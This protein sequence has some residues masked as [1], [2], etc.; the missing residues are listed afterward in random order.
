MPR[1]HGIDVN[2]FHPVYDWDRLAEQRFEIFGAKATNGLGIDLAFDGHRGG[3]REH[4]F[5]LVV[6]YHFPTPK[7]S[8]V[9]QADHFV[10]QVTIGGLGRNERLALD[11][12]YDEHNEW[13]PDIRFV[14]EFTQEVIRLIS[15]RRMFTYTSKRVWGDYMGGA[16]WPAAIATDA[17]L[18]HYGTDEPELPLDRQGFPLWPR[19]TMWQDSEEFRCPGVGLCDHNFFAGDRDQLL[20][21]MGSVTAD[22]AP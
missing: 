2:H 8:A 17:W 1:A 3:A 20:A 19:W 11:V 7:S 18:A 10:D 6:Y 22:P 21:Y 5:D 15:D 16:S 4:A 13:S 12:E 14:D 9:A